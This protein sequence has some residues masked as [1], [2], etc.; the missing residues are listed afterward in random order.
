MPGAIAFEP[1]GIGDLLRRSRHVVPPNQRSYAWESR[2]V[3]DLLQDINA[4]MTRSSPDL[5]EYFLGT[6]VLVEGKNGKP[7]SISDGQQRLATTSIILARI[8]DILKE[9]GQADR[10]S[11]IENDFLTKIDFDTGEGKPQV[12]LNVEDNTFFTEVILKSYPHDVTEAAFMRASNKRLLAASKTAYD[13][14]KNAVTG[15]GDANK[16]PYLGQW[17]RF[18]KER[19]HIIAVTVPDEN[20]AFRLFETLNDRGVKAGQV[21]LLKNY[22]LETAGSDRISE[23]HSLWSEL[24]GKIEAQYPDEDD[25][26]ILYLRHLWITKYGHTIEKELST[27]IR[28]N[29]TSPSLSANFIYEANQASLVY[30]ALSE[31]SHP[32]WNDYKN[33][34]REYLNTIIRHLKV[35]QIKPLLF[36]IAMRF[37]PEET[38][39]AFRFAL[40]ISVRFLIVGG[41]GGFLDE[42]YAAK[43][44]DVGTGKI[45]KA[46]ELREAMASIVPTNKQFEDAFSTARV[47]K[48]YLAR[49][50]LRAIEKTLRDDPDPEFVVNDDYDAT[51]L[52]HIVPIKPSSDWHMSADEAASAHTLIGNMTLLSAKINVEIGNQSFQE[53]V[54]SYSQSSYI[55]TNSLEKIIGGFGLEEIKIRQLELAKLAVKTWPLT[56]V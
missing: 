51:N 2:N 21:D 26:L 52:E 37:T 54:K 14:L 39:K 31:P 56:F 4:E 17:L 47:S 1:M 40:S 10:A 8:R 13:Y 7:P 30:I 36:A 44:H 12:G 11:S 41:R 46:S 22:F 29:I 27:K 9:M 49:Y 5:P 28:A 23:T 35:T 45:T 43:A 53:K 6:I 33:A 16:T 18:I 25:Q 42:H 55:I 50:Y 38:T 20:Q 32:L 3:R 19:T 15:F 24:T 34:T 48:G